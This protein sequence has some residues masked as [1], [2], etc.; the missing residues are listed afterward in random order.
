MINRRQMLTRVGGVA[1]SMTIASDLGRVCA[2]FQSSPQK[3]FGIFE[4]YWA[5]PVEHVETLNKNVYYHL[6]FPNVKF[7]KYCYLQHGIFNSQISVCTFSLGFTKNGPNFLQLPYDSES[8][9]DDIKND[10]A[11][12]FRCADPYSKFIDGPHRVECGKRPFT[13]LKVRY[14]DKFTYM[15][16]DISQVMI[17]QDENGQWGLPSKT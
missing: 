8:K 4:D 5:I 3:D 7:E 15:I 17:H 16:T 14:R 1:A 12:L 9:E 10:V 6:S 11:F 13:F 2:G